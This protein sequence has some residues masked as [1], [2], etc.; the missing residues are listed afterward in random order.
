FL[1]KRGSAEREGSTVLD[2]TLYDESTAILPGIHQAAGAAIS[3]I[4]KRT[5]R[6]SQGWEARIENRLGTAVERASERAAKAW[7][8][9][10][11][12][13]FISDPLE[14]LGFREILEQ[15]PA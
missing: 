6:I 15:L 11:R 8:P 14:G 3:R 13:S 12:E 5:T 7:E 1:L 9:A 10:L 4:E 2:E